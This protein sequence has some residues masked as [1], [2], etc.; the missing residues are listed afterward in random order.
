MS[1]GFAIDAWTG[2]LFFRFCRIY[3]I[4]SREDRIAI[5]RELAHRKKAKYLRDVEEFTDGK[6]VLKIGFKPK[7]DK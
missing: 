2:M 6:S 1:E 7:G 5:M 4:T 3:H